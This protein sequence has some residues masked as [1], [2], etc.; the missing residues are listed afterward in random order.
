[1]LHVVHIK[2][3]VVW[4]PIKLTPVLKFCLKRGFNRILTF[5]MM[6][7]MKLV[8]SKLNNNVLLCL[9]ETNQFIIAPHSI[10]QQDVLYKKKSQT[11]VHGITTCD[12][13]G[14]NTL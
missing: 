6:M 10:T 3:N 9:T 14:R 12:E 7:M 4:D 2:F 5:L 8:V 1:M 11:E 13:M